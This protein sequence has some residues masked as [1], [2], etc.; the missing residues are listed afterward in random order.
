LHS[1]NMPLAKTGINACG[2]SHQTG[3]ASAKP[4]TIKQEN[5]MTCRFLQVFVSRALR[6]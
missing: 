5:S 6:Q 2:V 1:D 4:G 3:V